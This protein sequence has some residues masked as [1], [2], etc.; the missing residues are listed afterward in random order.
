MALASEVA[1]RSAI[2][3]TLQT[4]SGI[5]K[6]YPRV[7][8][9]KQ[10]ALA[11]YQRVYCDDDGKVNVWMVRRVQRAP[12]VDPY[13]VIQKV[14]QTYNLIGFYSVVDNDDDATASEAV[15][16]KIIEDV[17]LA[18][19]GGLIFSLNGVYHRGLALPSDF[20]DKFLGD[21]L[22]HEVQ[23]RLVVDVE[24]C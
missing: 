3:T 14:V 18:F 19:E 12:E 6:V 4:V 10:G 23:C 17:A 5:G 13:D 9:P 21:I 7:R 8:R 24:D 15:F 11:D 1:I 22:C 16:Q 2:V 20:E